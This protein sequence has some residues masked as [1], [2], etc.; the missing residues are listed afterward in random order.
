MYTGERCQRQRYLSHIF[1]YVDSPYTLTPLV[2]TNMCITSSRR[3]L[4]EHMPHFIVYSLFLIV[5]NKPIIFKSNHRLLVPPFSTAEALVLFSSSKA[6]R[7]LGQAVLGSV[8]DEVTTGGGEAINDGM[9]MV[10]EGG[11]GGRGRDKSSYRPSTTD[12]GAYPPLP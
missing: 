4:R 2:D 3:I 5:Q 6:R 11:G 12:G 1:V 7:G 10:G 8:H 9:G